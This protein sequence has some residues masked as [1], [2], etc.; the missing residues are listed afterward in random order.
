[1]THLPGD[2]GGHALRPGDSLRLKMTI[3]GEQA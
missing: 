3:A 2:F 1:V